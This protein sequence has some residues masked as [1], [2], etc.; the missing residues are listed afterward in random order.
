MHEIRSR[1]CLKSI[2]RKEIR[3]RMTV[4][5]RSIMN[6]PNQE[7]AGKEGD[8]LVVKVGIGVGEVAFCLVH[9]FEDRRN[10]NATIGWLE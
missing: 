9:A 7:S 8:V 5:G 6:L 1:S 2:V 3:Y 10:S 4:V